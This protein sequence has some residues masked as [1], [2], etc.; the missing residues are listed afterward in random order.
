[1]ETDAAVRDFQI[2][3]RVPGE[4]GFDEAF[5]VVAPK[6]KDAAEGEREIDLVE[7]FAAF[8][9]CP[10]D[11]PGIAKLNLPVAI[12]ASGLASR[13]H[14][15]KGLKWP[16]GDDRV[17]RRGDFEHRCPQDHSSWLAM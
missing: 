6:S 17:A 5:Q 9:Q 8:R 7:D 13:T 3:H 1:M 16:C 11:G 14:G 10:E 12:T 15:L 4:A 2:L